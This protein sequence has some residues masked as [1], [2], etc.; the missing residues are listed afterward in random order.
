MCIRSLKP[1][2]FEYCYI[3]LHLQVII[4]LDVMSPIVKSFNRPFMRLWFFA[5]YSSRVWV[6]HAEF[7]LKFHNKVFVP[8]FRCVIALWKF[9]ICKYSIRFQVIKLKLLCETL[10]NEKWKIIVWY[11]NKM[12]W[13]RQWNPKCSN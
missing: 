5:V 11:P 12:Q 13:Y 1:I 6:E 4:G 10:K 8:T 9:W 7:S 2:I 3:M